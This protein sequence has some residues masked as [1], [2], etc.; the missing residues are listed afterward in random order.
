VGISY[1]VPDANET[2]DRIAAGRENVAVADWHALVGKR[3]GLLHSDATHPNMDG[4]E[5]Y[6]D[7]VERSFATLE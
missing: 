4:I 7:L 3:P 5:A 2:L 6:T 1:W